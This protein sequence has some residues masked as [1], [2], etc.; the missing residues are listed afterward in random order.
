MKAL[1]LWQPWA[2]LIAIG[3]KR[4]ETRSWD[5]LYRGPIA[6]HAAKKWDKQ[7]MDIARSFAFDSALRPRSLAVEHSGSTALPFGC[8]VAHARLVRVERITHGYTRHLDPLE[9]EFGN[10]TPGRFAFHFEHVQAL[11]T[12][13]PYRGAQGLFEL[14]TWANARIERGGV[15]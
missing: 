5:T 12:P 15:E 4:I 8:I 1:S 6:I 7:L 3:A 10:Y 13:I 11:Q 2:S 9:A 14:L